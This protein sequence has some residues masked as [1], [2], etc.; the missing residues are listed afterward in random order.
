MIGVQ[1]CDVVSLHPL[2]SDPLAGWSDDA[3]RDAVLSGHLNEFQALTELERR[4]PTPR[5][6]TPREVFGTR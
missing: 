5:V 1:L 2:Y 6:P 3:I 4:H